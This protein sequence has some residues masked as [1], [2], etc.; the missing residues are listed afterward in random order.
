MEDKYI[1]WLIQFIV[2]GILSLVGKLLWDI[3]KG[4]EKNA[5]ATS[6][7]LDSLEES[8]N[9]RVSELEREFLTYKAK[10]PFMYVLREDYLRHISDIGN[11]L[12]K[13]LASGILA[14]KEE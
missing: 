5:E 9:S 10:L 2:G 11:K 12:D 14:R 13:I 8:L 4:F 3:K 1:F 6:K 7:K